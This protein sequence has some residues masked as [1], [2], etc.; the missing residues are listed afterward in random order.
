V[1]RK[2]GRIKITAGI[3]AGINASYN[4][5]SSNLKFLPLFLPFSCQDLQCPRPIP[6]LLS[7]N[8]TNFM[9]LIENTSE[10]MIGSL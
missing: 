7:P 4:A 1:N 3:N 2:K 9:R 6:P 8:L 10:K 5:C